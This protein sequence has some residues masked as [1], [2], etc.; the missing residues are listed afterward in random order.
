MISSILTPFRWYDKYYQQNRWDIEC[1]SVCDFQLITDQQHLLPFQII[2]PS[3]LNTIDNWI[4]RPC[5][6]DSDQ[7]LLSIAESTFQT[8]WTKFEPS[9]W[10]ISDCL[11]G[12]SAT[13]PSGSYSRSIFYNKLI[14]GK[15][16]TVTFDINTLS[17]SGIMSLN[18]LMGATVIANYTTAGSKTFTYNN[19]STAFGFEIFNQSVGDVISINNVQIVQNFSFNSDDIYLDVNLLYLKNFGSFD[20]I[21][22][23]GVD[24]GTMYQSLAS[25][26]KIPPGCYYSVII[27]SEGGTYY[28]EVITVKNFDTTKSPYFI[29]EWYNTCDFTDVVFSSSNGCTYKNKLYLE[30]AVLTKPIYPFKEEGS[31]DGNQI[32]NPTFQKWQKVVSLFG[33]KLPEFIVDALTGIRLHDTIQ[34]Y[35]PIRQ[36]QLTL[37]SAVT[38]RSVEYDVQ[39]VVND[40]FAN[41]ELKMLLEDKFVDETCCNNLSSACKECSIVVEANVYDIDQGYALIYN[42]ASSSYQ[43]EQYLGGEWVVVGAY[44]G[45]NW[46]SDSFS[47]GDIICDFYK[48]D[49]NLY[50][51]WEIQADGIYF[52]PTIAPVYMS[53]TT[54]NVYADIFTNSFGQIEY[55]TD[56]VTW[57]SISTPKT[58]AQLIAGVSINFGIPCGTDFFIRVHQ[59]TLDCDYGYSTYYVAE[60]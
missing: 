56:A 42:D 41:V 60:C 5:C 44:V 34:Y 14:P 55:S 22:Y 27:D 35:Y 31:E 49:I 57:V 20:I 16:Y 21:S 26:Q 39:Y 9:Y 28:S 4:L 24:L 58:Q 40:C 2:R 43:I 33:Y 7:P 17:T 23:C 12:I 6:N 54:W 29:L 53:G 10:T 36:K 13:I 50:G 47:I 3:S 8:S 25:I 45:G 37:D 19:L 52:L 15:S 11:E 59:Y 38:V 1:K 46:Q 30:D 32:F 51:G 48:D 18:L